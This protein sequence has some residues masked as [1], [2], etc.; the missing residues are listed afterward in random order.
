MEMF[1]LRRRP[2]KVKVIA[3][4]RLGRSIYDELVDE[5]GSVPTLFEQVYPFEWP[6]PLAA[7]QD[8]ND[9]QDEFEW[10]EQDENDSNTTSSDK[11]LVDFWAKQHTQH[12]EVQAKKTL[13]KLT[14]DADQRHP[15][16][17]TGRPDLAS[18]PGDD[19]C[20]LINKKQHPEVR[21]HCVGFEGA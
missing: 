4:G 8:L 14:R 9:M 15:S 5:F 19:D 3:Y 13:A 12:L 11:E 20:Y 6:E 1:T 7:P 21:R 16:G 2:K 10:L 18:I 17:M